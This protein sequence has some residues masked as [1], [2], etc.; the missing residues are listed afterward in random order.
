MIGYTLHFDHF[1]PSREHRGK[2]KPMLTAVCWNGSRSS[3]VLMLIDCG[4]DNLVL[5]AETL[6]HLGLSV[7]ELEQVHARTAYGLQGAFQ[8][9]QVRFTVP[10]LDPD[11]GFTCEPV[12]SPMFD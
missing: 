6:D 12:F 4:A 5:P 7:D 3:D 11:W 10:D 1:V 9:P 8:G 2:F